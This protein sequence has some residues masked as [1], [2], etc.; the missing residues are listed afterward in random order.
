MSLREQ[1]PPKSHVIIDSNQDNP[2]QAHGE[3]GHVE[4]I[5]EERV[6]VVL[7]GTDDPQHDRGWFTPDELKPL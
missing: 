2:M 1:F 3:Q 6:M 4:K 7:D 5:G